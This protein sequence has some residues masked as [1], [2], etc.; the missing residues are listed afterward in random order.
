MAQQV[1]VGVDVGTG[2]A[3]AALFDAAHGTL[4]SVHVVPIQTWNTTPHHYEQSS[5]NIWNAVCTAVSTAFS[6]V[7]AEVQVKSIGFAATCSLV[8][9]GDGDQPLTVSVEGQEER[10]IVCLVLCCV[11]SKLLLLRSDALDGPSSSS[12]STRHQSYM[13]S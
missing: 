11:G 1:Y 8:L 10:N 7:G 3:R 13:Q 4:L 5:Q 6:N 9:L 2:S 12:G